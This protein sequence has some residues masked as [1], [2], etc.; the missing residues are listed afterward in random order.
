MWVRY[1]VT[2]ASVSQNVLL[3]SNR[4]SNCGKLGM[5]EYFPSDHVRVC[6]SG[7]NADLRKA[8][9]ARL[10]LGTR[11]SCSQNTY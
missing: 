10:P 8:E 11:A 9:V 7:P 4:A 2:M 3:A 1:I 5:P 6:G